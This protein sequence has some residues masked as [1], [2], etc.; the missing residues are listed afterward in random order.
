MNTDRFKL[1]QLTLPIPGCIS[2]VDIQTLNDLLGTR[3]SKKGWS[4]SFEKLDECLRRGGLICVV[5]DL[6]AESKIVGVAN[7]IPGYEIIGPSWSLGYVCTAEPVEGNGIAAAIILRLH[8]LVR[9]RHPSRIRLGVR[10]DNERAIALYE[11]LGYRRQGGYK[12]QID[13]T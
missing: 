12:Y 9:P 10:D 7:L 11:K 13:M 3:F 4:T 8:E 2:E 6:Q 1:E 5:R